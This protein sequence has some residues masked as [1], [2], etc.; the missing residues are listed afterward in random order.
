MGLVRETHLFE[1]RH[2]RGFGFGLACTAQHAR[3][4]GNVMQYRQMR[5]QIERLE[6][7]AD[8]GAQRIERALF[9]HDAVIYEAMAANIHGAAFGLLKAIAAAQ[10]GA[11]ARAAWADHD[12]DLLRLNI[13]VNAVQYHV[14]AERFGQ[15]ANL[16]DGLRCVAHCTMP[17]AR[18]RR[19]TRCSA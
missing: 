6:H 13:E 7:H 15:S 5:K 2:G 11:L 9:Q 8:F 10:K 18:K 3:T 17:P 19:S 14:R 16:D 4:N 12:H 1:Q